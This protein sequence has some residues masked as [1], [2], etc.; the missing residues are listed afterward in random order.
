MSPEQRDA[1]EEPHEHLDAEDQFAY[2]A[3]SRRDEVAQK[4]ETDGDAGQQQGNDQK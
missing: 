4:L 2:V 3:V 1:G